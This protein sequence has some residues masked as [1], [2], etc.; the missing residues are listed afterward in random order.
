M[1]E[2]N[3][4]LRRFAREMRREPTPAE[5]ALWRLI[6]NRQLGRLKFRRQHALGP[7]I[8]DCYC[9]AA[10][11]AIEL[12]GNSHATQEGQEADAERKSYLEVRG[13]LVLRFWNTEIAEN[14]DGVLERIAEVGLVRLQTQAEEPG[15]R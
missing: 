15:T 10:R 9:P 14:P 7:Y 13:I 5:E 8:L 11:L 1:R 4:N 3:K 12:D 6:R 2:D